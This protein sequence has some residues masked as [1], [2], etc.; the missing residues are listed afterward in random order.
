MNNE[1]TSI[2]R[3]DSRCSRCDNILNASLHKGIVVALIIGLKGRNYYCCRCVKISKGKFH[4]TDEQ[5]DD[6]VNSLKV[7]A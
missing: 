7:L 4:R 1:L 3:G 5:L 2:I 6:F